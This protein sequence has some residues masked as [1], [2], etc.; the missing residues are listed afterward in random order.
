MIKNI[1]LI[2][3]L[4]E[5]YKIYKIGYTKR[6]VISR[7]NELKTANPYELEIV[8]VYVAENYGTRIEKKLHNAFKSKR[9]NGEWFELDE[10]DIN[11]FQNMCELY[12][13]VFDS[14]KNNTYIEDRGITFK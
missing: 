11:E 14:L 3:A 8:E 4:I 1:Y 10:N 13:N 7:V 5:D 2:S 12:Y 6:N 9:M